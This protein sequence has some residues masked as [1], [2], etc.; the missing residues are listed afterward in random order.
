MVKELFERLQPEGCGQ[1]VYV[2]AEAS[3]E[4]RPP[5]VGLGTGTF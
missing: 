1:L 5:E 3:I 4:Q 2:Q